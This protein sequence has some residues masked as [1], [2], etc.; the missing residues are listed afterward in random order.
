[1][2]K[3]RINGSGTL[4]T[5]TELRNG[6]YPISILN[7]NRLAEAYLMLRNNEKHRAF[8]FLIKNR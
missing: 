3:S 8:D 4:K 7:K 6:Y 1:M 5:R 2:L